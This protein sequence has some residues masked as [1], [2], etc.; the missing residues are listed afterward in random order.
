M[1]TEL[2]DALVD[3]GDLV[4]ILNGGEPVGDGHRCARLV[5]VKLVQG[6]LDHLLKKDGPTSQ[7]DRPF[8]QTITSTV[9][10]SQKSVVRFAIMN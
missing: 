1:R 8:R 10:L 4:S 2:D 9:T 6:C 7:Q 3:D 5:F